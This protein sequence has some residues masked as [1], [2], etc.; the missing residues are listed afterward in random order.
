MFFESLYK[1]WILNSLEEGGR[2]LVIRKDN[3]TIGFLSFSINGEQANISLFSVNR[4]E[5]DKGFGT[6]LYHVLESFLVKSGVTEL[7][8]GT[9]QE[10]VRACHFYEKL[11]FKLLKQQ[12]I[13]HLWR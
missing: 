3:Q 1:R 7:T 4:D 2:L 13:Y 10:N 5:L 6:R 12:N 8:I 11:G 9:Q